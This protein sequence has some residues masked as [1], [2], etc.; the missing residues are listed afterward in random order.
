MEA[1]K[2]RVG[3]RTTARLLKSTKTE[4]IQ[5]REVSRVEALANARVVVEFWNRLPVW[6]RDKDMLNAL[7][8]RVIDR[9][10]TRVEQLEADYSDKY[11][12]ER[13]YAINPPLKW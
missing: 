11:T 12:V 7:L 9:G 10:Y 3:Y 5:E 2:S 8:F 4:P 6:E 1:V 13:D